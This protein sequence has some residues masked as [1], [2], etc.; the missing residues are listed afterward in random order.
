VWKGDFS[1]QIL[2][3]LK[4]REL[5]LIDPWEFRPTFPNRWYGGAKA[6]GQSDMDAIHAGVVSRFR[7]QKAV[8]IHRMTSLSAAERFPNES[9]DWV[10]I[11]GDHSHDAVKADL[12][13]WFPKIRIGGALAGDDYDWLDEAGAPSVQRAVEEV[14]SEWR[15]GPAEVDGGQYRI[16]VVARA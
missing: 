12:I 3:T 1:A 14:L 4:P 16:R 8:R 9:L 7:G 6:A 11:D 10:Y 13:A 2:S 5:H 15:M